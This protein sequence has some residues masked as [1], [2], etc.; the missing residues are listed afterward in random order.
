MFHG[1]VV[2]LQLTGELFSVRIHNNHSLMSGVELTQ[3][4]IHAHPEQI[5]EPI[6]KFI[7]TQGLK[8]RWF[9]I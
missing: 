4:S 2:T 1:Q 8:E 7:L 3:L 6:Q 5:A 9:L